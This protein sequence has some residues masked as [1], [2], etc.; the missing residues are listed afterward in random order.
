[1]LAGCITAAAA[2]IADARIDCLDLVSGGVAAIVE[3]DEEVQKDGKPARRLV[4]DPDPS[5]HKNITAACVVACLPGR[6]EI[7]ELWLKGD[8]SLD[9][10]RGSG[11]EALI[12]GSVDAAKCVHTVLCAAVTES[13]ERFMK[14]VTNAPA[15]DTD[16]EM[17]T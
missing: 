5:E 17:K 12:D 13:G 16:V 1:M 8:T 7:T 6:D 3:D 9:G 14:Q 15:A 10:D 4:L 11:H 2:A